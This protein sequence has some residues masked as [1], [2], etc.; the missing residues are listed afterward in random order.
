MLVSGMG[1]RSVA[2]VK[3]DEVDIARVV[4]LIGAQLAHAEHD[5]AAA[6]SGLAAK[7]ELPLAL[8]SQ[9]EGSTAR[10]GGLRRIGSALPSPARASMLRRCRRPRSVSAS[11]RLRR[12]RR[13]AAV[14]GGAPLRASVQMASRVGKGITVWR[15]RVRD[16]IVRSRKPDPVGPSRSD[17]GCC[18]TV[19]RARPLQPHPPGPRRSLS[20]ASTLRRAALGRVVA[21]VGSSKPKT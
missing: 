12:R 21:A 3:T 5:E 19:R 13:G 4:E 20:T 18:R 2:V 15:H 1:V 16:G 7:Q 10:R 11:R 9:Q 6:R 8:G 14:A 17:R